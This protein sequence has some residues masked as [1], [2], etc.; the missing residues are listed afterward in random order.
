M[1]EQ[2]QAKYNAV[3]EDGYS[4]LVKS[5]PAKPMEAFIY[6]LWDHLGDQNDLKT[7]DE[8][9]KSFCQGY[10]ERNGGTQSAN[11]IQSTPLI[12]PRQSN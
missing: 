3:I 7:K 4:R 1:N 9:L 8:H 10:K 11:S 12:Q 5:R 6:Y 2:D